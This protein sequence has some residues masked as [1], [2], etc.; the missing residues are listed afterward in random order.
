MKCAEMHVGIQ[1]DDL[2]KMVINSKGSSF[3]DDYKM[4]PISLIY[5][6]LSST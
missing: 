3:A 5:N 6:I 2:V 1:Y 4:K